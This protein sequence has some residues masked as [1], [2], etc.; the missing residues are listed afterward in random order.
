MQTAQSLETAT[1][2][3]RLTAANIGIATKAKATTSPAHFSKGNC[4]STT[5]STVAATIKGTLTAERD[6]FVMNVTIAVNLI[7]H[8][9]YLPWTVWIRRTA[10][11]RT[12]TTAGGIG[13]ALGVDLPTKCAT[14][15]MGWTCCTT[16]IYS[17]VTTLT[18]STV[19]TAQC[20]TTATTTAARTKTA[21]STQTVDPPNTALTTYVLAERMAGILTISIASSIG[22]VFEG[23]EPVSY[24][25][26]VLSTTF[27]HHNNQHPGL[28]YDST[29]TLSTSS[30]SR[31]YD[32]RGVPSVLRLS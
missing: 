31:R 17:I 32:L 7:K 6:L 5:S 29:S 8:V 16:V 19:A 3:I 15:W 14:P 9:T 12:P 30:L 18:S 22:S 11:M 20:A 24:V 28:F 10:G 2:L 27:P 13:I 1:S 21:A 25:L 4:W 26:Q 23:E